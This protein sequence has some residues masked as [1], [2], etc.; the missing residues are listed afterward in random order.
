MLAQLVTLYSVLTGNN[1]TGY[2]TF[3]LQVFLYVRSIILPYIEHT[4]CKKNKSIIFSP[5]DVLIA[6]STI[7]LIKSNQNSLGNYVIQ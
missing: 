7:L 6:V 2:N 4:G 1:N 5:A 3:S